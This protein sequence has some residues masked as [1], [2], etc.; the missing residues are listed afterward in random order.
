MP[1]SDKVPN[2]QQN[3]PISMNPKQ[4]QFDQNDKSSNHNTVDKLKLIDEEIQKEK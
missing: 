2:H 4:L 3:I 1:V